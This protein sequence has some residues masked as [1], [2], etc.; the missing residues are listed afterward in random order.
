M[1]FQTLFAP[2]SIFLDGTI[3][4]SVHEHG[5]PAPTFIVKTT[6]SWAV[7]INWTNTGDLTP[8]VGGTYDLHLLLERMGPGPDFDLTDPFLP[9]HRVPLTPG[10]A[11]VNYFRHVDVAANVVPAGVYKLVVLIRYF[12]LTGQPGPVAAYEEISPLIQFYEP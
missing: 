9:D 6:D 1:P 3:T 11:P 2:G 12:D 4:A 7:N 5:N 10:P 8:M